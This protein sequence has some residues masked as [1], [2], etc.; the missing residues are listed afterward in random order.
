MIRKQHYVAFDI[1]TTGLVADSRVVSY[2]LLGESDM[3]S[4]C[5][6]CKETEM[7]EQLSVDVDSMLGGKILVTFNG[8]NW[9]GGF[10]IPMLRTRYVINDMIDQYPF[11]GVKHIDLMPLFH[12]KFNTSTIKEPEIDDMNAAQ[13][14]EVV[15]MCNQ[16]PASTKALNVEILRD[17]GEEFQGRIASYLDTNL[18]HKVVSR[19]GLK[20]CHQMFFGGEIETTGADVAKMW[21]SGEYDKIAA[22]NKLDCEM[23]TDLLELCLKIVPEYDMRYFVM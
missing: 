20:H 12:K 21:E 5:C 1:E 2:C 9:S 11:S 13:C 8:E 16:K 22:Y 19:F 7:L 3:T 18:E 15:K 10:D 17:A 4:M 14:K 6:D 23:T